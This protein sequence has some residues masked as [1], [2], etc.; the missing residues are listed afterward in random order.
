MQRLRG[1][2]WSLDSDGES[3]MTFTGQHKWTAILRM[4]SCA[5]DVSTLAP[6]SYRLRCLRVWSQPQSW[7]HQGMS[8]RCIELEQFHHGSGEGSCWSQVH[9]TPHRTSSGRI[10]DHPGEGLHRVGELPWSCI[11]WRCGAAVVGRTIAQELS[12][13]VE[14]AIAPFQ[15]ALPPRQGANVWHT[16]F[17]HSCP[18]VRT[19]HL[20]ESHGAGVEGGAQVLPFSTCSVD[21]HRCIGG[22]IPWAQCTAVRTRSAPCS[23]GTETYTWFAC[24]TGWE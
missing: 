18:S 24:P 9:Q 10:C 2:P 23:G 4:I 22:R 12:K 1:V 21:D 14:G 3:P 6:Q 8:P 19:T 11:P 7:R 20:Q 15:Y 16:H 5:S 17:R 13:A